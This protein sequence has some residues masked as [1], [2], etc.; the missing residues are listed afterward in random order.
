[1]MCGRV[2]WTGVAQWLQMGSYEAAEQMYKG[3]LASD[4]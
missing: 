2:R 4:S 1:M 3:D